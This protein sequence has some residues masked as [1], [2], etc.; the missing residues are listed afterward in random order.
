ML[1]ASAG[2]GGRGMR[3]VRNEAELAPMLA[4]AQAEAQAAF[5]NGDIYMEK[6]VEAPKAHIE[7]RR[8]WA[9]STAMSRFS[10]SANAPS[11]GGIRSCWKNRL[12]RR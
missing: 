7:F 9:M 11:S 2:G 12:P 6:L 8:C 4:Q 10:A 3:I 5:S 1:K